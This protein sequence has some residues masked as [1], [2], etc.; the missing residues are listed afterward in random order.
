MLSIFY[1]E[2][3][4]GTEKRHKHFNNEHQS[5]P[6]FSPAINIRIVYIVWHTRL[7][8]R[9]WTAEEAFPF[10]FFLLSSDNIKVQ[11]L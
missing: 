8:G 2:M 10:R 11:L 3:A 9:G 5:G 7:S 1:D 4:Q 6:F